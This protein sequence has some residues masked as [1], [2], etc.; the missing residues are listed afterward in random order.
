MPSLFTLQGID[1]TLN[2]MVLK[3][4]TLKADLLT[5]IRG[6]FSDEASL[7][8]IS[9]IPTDE[10]VL[11]LWG[12]CPREELKAKKKNFSS[13][14]S[15]INKS[16]KELD[17]T[18]KNPAGIILGRDNVFIVSEER[19]DDL[20]KQLG[21]SADSP[22]LFRDMLNACKKLFPETGKIRN[23]HEIKD[24]LAELESTR[25]MLEEMAGFGS[26]ESRSPSEDQHVENTADFETQ[27]IEPAED[28]EIQ[29]LDSDQALPDTGSQEPGPQVQEIE[30]AEDEEIQLLDSDQTLPDTGS[31]EPGPQVQEIEL[32]EDEEIQF[33]D[34]DQALPD[35]GSREPGPKVQ[36]IEL[37]E[38]E[39]IR[40]SPEESPIVSTGKSSSP[41]GILGVLS[42]YI[43]AAQALSGERELLRET[44][45]EFIQ[46]ILDRFM[47]KF[48]R[49]PAGIYIVGSNNP[50]S[51][52]QIEKRVTLG[53]FYLGQAPVTNDLFDLFIRE[54]GYVTDA[55]KTGYGIVFEG[56][57]T[58][59]VDPASG[60]KTLTLTH[61]TTA[62]HISGADW[63]HPA[64][65]ESSLEGKH[66]HP[67][68]QVS[69][70]DARAFAAWAGKRLPSE[71]EWEA[72][73][74]GPE[75]RPFPWG[76]TWQADHGN[77]A[78]ACLGSTTPVAH[79]GRQAM[80][81]F[82][83]YDLLGNVAEWTAT[84]YR[85]KNGL[86]AAE[87]LYVV[88]GG[89]WAVEG[90]ISADHRQVE[91]GRHWTNTIGFRCAV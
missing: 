68:V 75:G 12:P 91:R 23:S 50:R 39:E 88:K 69:H 2:N 22:H 58:S 24:L 33:L 19:K 44:R 59:R 35:T 66:D 1:E 15:A 46:Q 32:A 18:G 17:K 70:D 10:L 37:A 80:S 42:K 38:D 73:A 78:S 62:R 5:V 3:P 21:F 85:K 65:P 74:R 27:E 7:Q 81:P 57:C 53:D 86:P 29:F 31:Q 82:G 14:K 25:K 87:S 4:G 54:T 30:L 61:G 47:P 11:K 28:E 48:I 16:F 89:G 6:Y 52:E 63:R 49:I 71:E 34:S 9:G 84:L 72:A 55:E 76:N 26:Q 56:R 41:P 67:V 8:S 20:L 90:I 13:L 51:L 45:E 77:F 60:R 64:G 43:N 36:E 40:L 79:F 83:I